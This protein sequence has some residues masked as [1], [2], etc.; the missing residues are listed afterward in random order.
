MSKAKSKTQG[1]A[2][3][4]EPQIALKVTS[5]REGFRRGGRAWAKGV[6]IVALAGLS[7]E[8]IAQIEGEE[9]FEVERVEI[10][11]APAAEPQV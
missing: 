7:E 8:Q 4:D 9:L 11:A 5:P 2:Q 3:P 10:A 1:A 6:T